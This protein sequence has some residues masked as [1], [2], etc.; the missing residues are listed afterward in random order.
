MSLFEVLSAPN[1]GINPF[2]AFIIT[3]KKEALIKE[4]S[5]KAKILE[6]IENIEELKKAIKENMKNNILGQNC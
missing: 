3:K 6:K 5:S 4:A 1:S 2:L